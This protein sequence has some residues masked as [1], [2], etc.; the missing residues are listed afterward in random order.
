M[1]PNVSTAITNRSKISTN[2]IERRV[3]LLETFPMPEKGPD[4]V[5]TIK[6]AKIKN[7]STIVY[8]MKHSKKARVR[9]KNYKRFVEE[10]LNPYFQYRRM[11]YVGR[12]KKSKYD[13]R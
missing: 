1:K 2:N 9:K 5:V 11:H 3:Q 7:V 10:C 4:P 8:L 6:R 12:I 13:R